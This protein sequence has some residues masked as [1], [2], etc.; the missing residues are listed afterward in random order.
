MATHQN[1]THHRHTHS[2]HGGTPSF[3]IPTRD[4][5]PPPHREQQKTHQPPPPPA[6]S[7]STS[8]SNASANA[9]LVLSSDSDLT[10]AESTEEE[11]EPGP[12][13]QGGPSSSKIVVE[14]VCLVC[15]GECRCGGANGAA[16][17]VAPTRPQ[18]PLKVR[19]KM[20]AP[21]A[22]SPAR[23]VAPPLPPL[24]PLPPPPIASTSAHPYSFEPEPII[25]RARRGSSSSANDEYDPRPLK[26][27]KAVSS[28]TGS[29][30]GKAV[31]TSGDASRKR[32]RPRSQGLDLALGAPT[33]AVASTSGSGMRKASKPSHKKRDPAHSYSAS[34]SAAAIR[35][36][37]PS[38]MS[39]RQV[40]AMSVREATQSANNSENEQT[41]TPTTTFTAA[42]ESKGQEEPLSDVSDLDLLD[43]DDESIE[44]AE[45][46]ALRAEFEKTKSKSAFAS[47]SEELT[48]LEEDE[49]EEDDD[50]AAGWE[51]HLKE[52]E[53]VRGAALTAA[54]KSDDHSFED[55]VN[56]AITDLPPTGGLGV[57][58][59]SDYDSVDMD[60]DDDE[61]GNLAHDFEEELEE[62]LAISEAV[63]GP[64]R[65]DELELGELWFEEMSEMGDD[66]SGS[67]AD[68]ES[69]E[70]ESSD[71]DDDDDGQERLLVVDGGW[72][73]QTR[74]LSGSSAGDS[75]DS[76]IYFDDDG[77]T[78][79][80]IDSEDHVRFGIEGPEDEDT[81]SACSETDYYRDAPGTASL[82]DVQAP[83]TADLASLP[84]FLFAADSMMIDLDSFDADPEQALRAAA[85]GLG[86]AIEEKKAVAAKA[87]PARP[88]FKGKSKM[89]DIVEEDEAGTGTDGESGR[90][91]AMG[92]FSKKSSGR[93]QDFNVVVID[94]SDN[95][96]PS[97]F[98]KV[99]K[100][101]KRAGELL[102]GT[103]SRRVRAAS[104]VSTTSVTDGSISG[105]VAEIS[106]VLAPA[107]LDFE[108]DDV[109]NESVLEDDP[110]PSGSSSDSD[111]E[112]ADGLQNGS[113]TPKAS[114]PAPDSTKK[115]S[116]LSDLSRWS[117]I[118]IG[119]FRS[120]T[121]RPAPQF[122]SP[123]VDNS[124]RRSRDKS[125]SN[126]YLPAASA[127]LRG[128]RAV[129]SLNHTL[130][131]PNVSNN[132]NKRAIERRML[133]SPVF[134]PV[135]STG[136]VPPLG[137]AAP[138]N[139]DG[140]KRK[141]RKKERKTPTNSRQNSPQ[142]RQRSA[143]TASASLRV[144]TISPF[145]AAV[146]LPESA[147]LF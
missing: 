82:A 112:V 22:P 140:E 65:D 115:A 79:D 89:I 83:T 114:T 64:V 1:H 129:T 27:Q 91:P 28:A 73:H 38:R 108:L 7:A 13:R 25:D 26:K 45:E 120:S 123:V 50:A 138:S 47:E 57:V 12:P 66:E 142:G 16:V 3:E 125:G 52:T 34:S 97:P 107:T 61:G 76:A 48:E 133:T 145:V 59:W 109:L 121:S 136:T 124:G 43:S 95:F 5:L 117:R 147:P 42:S 72:A 143:S 24:P 146:G 81:D 74:S 128:S 132:T 135:V 15:H 99:K 84:Q 98:S 60:D 100:N 105:E 11:D 4:H 77:D 49:D 70:G 93:P 54:V 62:L 94:G 103:P 35:A 20:S 88:P 119:A 78:T 63:V 37:A 96:A 139:V 102:E 126:V 118:P 32:G 58:T 17:Y 67:A 106:P 53:R 19:L 46:R 21:A 10:E 127:V 56:I 141:G 75:D 116:A 9:F 92:T 113:T 69:E 55:D 144:P 111:A 30:K 41:D 68:D 80:S 29:R 137:G 86:V 85:E 71:E 130:S 131:S 31:A 39:L 101:R 44:K 122:P 23:A 134:G 6:A 14:D 87:S 36:A 2:K 90:T 104:K 40:L 51:R 33:S 18:G 8:I 110:S